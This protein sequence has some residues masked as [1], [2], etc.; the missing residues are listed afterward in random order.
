VS[1]STAV[2]E[3]RLIDHHVH[4]VLP[5]PLARPDFEQMIT[6]AEAPAPA[7]TSR[8][9]SQLGF[10]V[11]RWCGPVLGLEASAAPDA[12]LQH[13]NSLP[14]TGS[15]DR[16]LSAAGCSHLLVDTGFI[17]PGSLS[18][19]ALGEAAGAVVHEVV[20]LETVAEELARSGCTATDFAD[21]FRELLWQRSADAVGVKSIVAYRYGLDFDPFRPG[22]AEVSAAAGNWLREIEVTGKV[23]LADPV[24]HRHLLWTAVDRGLPIQ[25]HTGFG[26][27]DLDLHR[28]NPLLARDFLASCGVPVV[29]LHCYPYHRQA[30]FLAQLYPNV[31]AD[32][33][34]TMNYL[35]ARA[36]A[37]LAEALELAPFGKVLY[38]S[39]AYGLPELIYLG[40]RL[41]RNAMIEVL[42]GWVGAGLWTEP[43]AIR[44]AGLIAAENSARLYQL[45][46]LG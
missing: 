17:A 7:G 42:G 45:T 23:R 31:Y 21:R 39:D 32:I 34:M 25:V 18:L 41:W 4:T 11:R 14:G 40:A 44:V 29:L 5:G 35:G 9:D 27:P 30:G 37:V 33:G 2:E 22:G 6:E 36:A 8:F 28:A 46:D 20:R 16:L 24:L 15:S 43:D 10:A 38:S 12:Y 1:L 19:A 3:L 26:D 13:R